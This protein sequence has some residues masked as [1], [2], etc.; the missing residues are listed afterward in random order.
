LES[1]LSWG[2]VRGEKQ[3]QR[4]EHECCEAKRD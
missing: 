2:Q 3:G 1:I 4:V